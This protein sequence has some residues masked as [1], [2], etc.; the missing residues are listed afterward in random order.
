MLTIR[1]EPIGS[2]RCT[3]R[4]NLLCHSTAT[5]YDCRR[6]KGKLKLWRHHDVVRWIFGRQRQQRLHLC[7]RSEKHLVDWLSLLFRTCYCLASTSANFDFGL[8]A[9]RKQLNSSLWLRLR[10]SMGTSKLYSI[11]CKKT[12]YLTQNSVVV[13]VTQDQLSVCHHTSAWPPVSGGLSVSKALGIH[14]SR[15]HKW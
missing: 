14:T 15:T 8:L 9:T 7:S 6:S 5:R 11:I 10:S 13:V 3:E 12:F 1:S 4:F 2:Q